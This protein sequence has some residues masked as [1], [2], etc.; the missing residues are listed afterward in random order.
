MNLRRLV[1]ILLVLAI[2][3]GGAYLFIT[4]PRYANEEYHDGDLLITD[5]YEITDTKLTIDGSILVNGEGKLIAKNSMITV[6]YT[7]LTLPTN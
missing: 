2:V 3:S 1:I 5:V 4:T 6:S 7:H